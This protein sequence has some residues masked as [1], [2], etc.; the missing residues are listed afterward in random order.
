MDNPDEL[1][2]ATKKGKTVMMFVRVTNFVDKAET[3][4]PR[5][6]RD[7]RPKTSSSSD[8]PRQEEVEAAAALGPLPVEVLGALWR[9][10]GMPERLEDG[11]STRAF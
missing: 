10:R 3:E 5:L 1:M 4:D 6:L 11:M 8:T 9:F 7:F 2:M